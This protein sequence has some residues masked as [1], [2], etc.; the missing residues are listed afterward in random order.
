MNTH[1]LN[2]DLDLISDEDISQLG[3][4]F[5]KHADLIRCEKENGVWRAVV[6]AA[7]SG[8]SELPDADI[9]GLISVVKKMDPSLKSQLDTCHVRDFNIGVETGNTR[10]FNIP[11]NNSTLSKIAVLGFTLSFT[12]YP[13]G[14]V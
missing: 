9:L 14:D 2:T 8:T 6:E 12:T 10:G 13:S 7:G 3:A 1:Y 5:D 11:I 4:Y